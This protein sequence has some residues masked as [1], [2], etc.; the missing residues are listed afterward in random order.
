MLS[1]ENGFSA[2]D[3]L[4]FEE[5]LARFLNRTTPVSYVTEPKLDGLAVEILYKD[6]L[7]I[8]ASTRGDGITGEEISAQI[9]T[10]QAIPLRLRKAVEGILEVRGEVF[11]DGEGFLRLNEEQTRAGRPPFANPRNA[12]AGSLRQLDPAIT[13][14]R[15]LKF[16][17]YGVS[18]PAA[19][20]CAT[21]FELL[22]RSMTWSAGART[23]RRS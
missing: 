14:S 5:R 7:M 6:G 2:E 21:Q 20:G 22:G 18:D 4:A 3:L 8:Q 16:Y 17:T 15:P 9:R 11:M 10:I 19:T 13:A 12:A 1:L 23:C